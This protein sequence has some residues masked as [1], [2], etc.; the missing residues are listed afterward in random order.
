MYSFQNAIRIIGLVTLSPSERM[1]LA[2]KHAESP[3]IMSAGT[4]CAV[5][6]Y[7]RRIAR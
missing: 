2:L 7:L 6:E 4:R 3:R 5:R 1:E